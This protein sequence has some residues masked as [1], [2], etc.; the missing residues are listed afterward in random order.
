MPSLEGARD[1]A[2]PELRRA[3]HDWLKEKVAQRALIIDT[4]RPPWVSHEAI[5]GRWMV[6]MCLR[7]RWAREKLISSLVRCLCVQF[8]VHTAE[9]LAATLCV[10]MDRDDS[11]IYVGF[12]ISSK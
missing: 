2:W 7:L 6:A 3:M 10:C 8:Q 1:T 12:R 9:E 11:V 4:D 5:Y